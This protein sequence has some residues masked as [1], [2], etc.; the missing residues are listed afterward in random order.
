MSEDDP[1][2]VELLQPRDPRSQRWQPFADS[3]PLRLSRAQLGSE[4]TRGVVRLPS[5]DHG[6]VIAAGYQRLMA[7]R[8]PRRRHDPDTRDQLDLA[9]DFLIRRVREVDQL[10][11][12]VL[13]L[14][15]AGQLCRLHH[16]RTACEGRIAP[17]V[18]EVQVAVDHPADITDRSVGVVQRLGQRSPSRSVVPLGLCVGLSEAGVKQQGPRR[19]SNEVSEDELDAGLTSAGLLRGSDEVPELDAVDVGDAQHQTECMDADGACVLSPKEFAVLELLLRAG[20]AVVSAEQILERAW[21]EAADPF[22]QA[23]KTTISRLRVKLGNPQILETVAKSGYR[24][25]GS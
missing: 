3:F 4:S 22:S 10:G 9:V 5:Q 14:P 12:R 25:A 19:M 2:R 7:C 13:G 6:S 1:T 16:N 8:V 21:D 17:T 24:I 11:D 23:V 15:S 18:I 20:G